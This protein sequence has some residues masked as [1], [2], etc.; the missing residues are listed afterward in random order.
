[1]LPVRLSLLVLLVPVLAGC[2]ASPTGPTGP[3]GGA[4]PLAMGRVACI[5]EV[6]N[7]QATVEPAERQA[8]ELSMAVNP[9]DPRNILATGKDYT[10]EHAGDCVW[11][12]LYVTKDGGATWTNLNLPGSPWK[13]LQDPT[14]PLTEF[15][16]YWCATD[17][18]VRFG[19]DGTA[20]W[21]VMPYQC[22]AASGSKVGR[23]VVPQGG[24]NDWLWTCVSMYVLVSED[25][26]LTWPTVRRVAVGERL[27]H[28]RQ[29]INVAP[30]GER[31][32][33]CW[34]FGG[35]RAQVGSAL[36]VGGEAV[37]E[38]A[39]VCS[40]SRDKGNSWTEPAPVGA[41]FVS[42]PV[43]DFGPDGT[44]WIAGQS[45]GEVVVLSSPDGLTWTA[46]VTVAEYTMPEG[47]GEHG[48]PVLRG[49][50]FRISAWPHLAVDRTDGPYAGR[51][52]V[53]WFD[54]TEGNGNVLLSWSDDGQ[55]WSA[56][57]Q[58][59][60]DGP[61]PH[62]QFLPAVSVGPDGILDVSWYDR[63]DDP[64]NRLFH[65]YHT[66]SVDGGRTFAPN[67]RVTTE[68]S[69]ETHSR[70]QNGMVFLGDYRDSGSTSGAAHVVWVDT[71][72]AKADAFVAT[73][74]RP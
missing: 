34:R 18:V 41:R 37:G 7:F 59:H 17:P 64:D 45:G 43:L 29:W 69:D 32:L 73:I 25:G 9:L 14:E 62:D 4:A 49:S 2:I 27:V 52:Y 55:V 46:P 11:D 12:G 51:V 6:C 67:L 35:E 30:D 57:L 48:R 68:A 10:P 22:D 3:L 70:H 56:P 8:N 31:V 74:L 58:V 71:R 40:Q 15:S 20:Y 50:E 63:R 54:H 47:G 53:A 38:P 5:G 19:P 26:G 66:Y 60:D 33:L 21:T 61:S 16:N 36:P 72:N 13:R 44:A 28:D 39:L 42:S 65:L 23:G 1:M 24:F